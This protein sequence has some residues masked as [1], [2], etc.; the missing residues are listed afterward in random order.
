VMLLD[1]LVGNFRKSF[2]PGRNLSVD[3]TMVGF[4]WRFGPKQYMPDKPTKY[5]I[6]AFTLA[7]SEH[8]YVF[9]ILLYTGSDTLASANPATASSGS[10]SS[11]W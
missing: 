4:H 9:D 10:A 8:R 7:E 5:G 3:E 6:K 2:A 1:L 11:A